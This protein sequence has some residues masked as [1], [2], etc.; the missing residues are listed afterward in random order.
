MPT[1]IRPKNCAQK[2]C[3]WR[4]G[5]HIY[6]FCMSISCLLSSGM[7][8]GVKKLGDLI[9]FDLPC[10]LKVSSILFYFISIRA[11]VENLHIKNCI[12]YLMVVMSSYFYKDN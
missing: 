11:C 2:L 3:V 5:G 4:P 12:K 7:K 1:D 6:A 8:L 10:S 9:D